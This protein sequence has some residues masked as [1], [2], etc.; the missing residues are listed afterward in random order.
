MLKL[1]LLICC[2]CCT[3]LPRAVLEKIQIFLVSK[4]TALRSRPYLPFFL[5]RFHPFS[6]NPTASER[7]RVST[8][9]TVYLELSYSPISDPTYDISRVLTYIRPTIRLSCRSWQTRRKP[10]L[11]KMS[12]VPMSR[13]C[14][15]SVRAKTVHR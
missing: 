9:F 13:G 12:A 8:H 4:A 5:F 15:W 6:T 14:C 3:Y 11:K 1:Q 7:S 10:C 2:I